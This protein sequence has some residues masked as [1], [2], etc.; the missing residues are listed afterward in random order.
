MKIGII[1]TPE[2]NKTKIIKALREE[3]IEY[4]F[5]NLIDNDWLD[6]FKGQFDGYLIYPPSFPYEWTNL[7]FKRLYY[8]NSL[9]R[10]KST[11]SLDTVS[12]Y[13]SKIAMHDFY[14]LNNIPH[15][16]ANTFYNMQDAVEYAHGCEL[17]VVVKEDQ[18]SGAV[19]VKIISERNK[20]FKL[21]KKSFYCNN[22]INSV[23]NLK[24]IKLKLYPYKL[25]IK[26]K[27]NYFPLLAK[28]VGFIH[29]QNYERVKYEWRIIRIGKSY[30][31]HK[32]LEDDAGF[33]S[34]SLN[35]GWGEVPEEIL[36]LVREVSNRT[37][38]DNANFD[39]FETEKG[40]LYFNEIQ[41]IFGTST[42]EQLK[43]KNIP[44]RY[45]Y[46]KRNWIFEPGPFAKNGCNNLRIQHLIQLLKKN[47]ELINLND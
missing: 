26:N 33:H 17:P 37:N 30:F 16:E 10:E 4:T 27:K 39:L 11:P 25:A 32:K 21:I 42:E 36:N 6:F 40:N 47:D 31:G 13:E 14:K 46:E 8:I 18:G 24:N 29:I 44:G 45:I 2:R 3:K 28:R 15:I 34:G 7:F 23:F 38:L 20:L 41:A 19:G 9:I 5:I 43:I 22:Q 12:M 1:I 35:K